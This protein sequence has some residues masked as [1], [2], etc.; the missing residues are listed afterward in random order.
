MIGILMALIIVMILSGYYLWPKDDASPPLA[1]VSIDRSRDV[2]YRANKQ[3][4]QTQIEVFRL[5][6]PNQPVS[7]EALRRANMTIPECPHCEWI[8]M[9][10]G[11]VYST[12]EPPPAPPEAAA[13]G[14]SADRSVPSGAAGPAGQLLQQMKQSR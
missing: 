9:S 3:V 8:V 6:Y 13:G 10:N 12:L 11:E 14:D 4:L 5:N 1:K 2:A 7:L